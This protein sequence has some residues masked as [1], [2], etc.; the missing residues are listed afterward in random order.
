MQQYQTP[1][2]EGHEKIK[3]RGK[4]RT[5]FSPS[6][7]SHYFHRGDEEPHECRPRPALLFPLLLGSA[8]PPLLFLKITPPPA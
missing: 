8:P 4:Q 3:K 2:E 7:V 6:P 1:D 5:M